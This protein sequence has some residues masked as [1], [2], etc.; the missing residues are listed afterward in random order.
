MKE[1]GEIEAKIEIE[2]RVNET[3]QKCGKMGHLLCHH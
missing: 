3:A 1:Q 2:R